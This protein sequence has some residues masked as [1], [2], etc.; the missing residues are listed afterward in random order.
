VL[1]DQ[2]RKLFILDSTELLRNKRT[3][4]GRRRNAV[5]RG[6]LLL[7]LFSYSRPITAALLL[8]L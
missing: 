6:R 4:Q 8:G 7:Q 3:G 1:F 2:G 5:Q